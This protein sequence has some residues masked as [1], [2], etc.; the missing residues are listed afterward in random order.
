MT[1]RS[2]YIQVSTAV[3]KRA[4]AEKIARVMVEKKLAACVQIV[5]PIISIYRW[6]GRMERSKEW[7]LIIKTTKGH[8][9][10]VEKAIAGAH[11]YE[12]P[13]IIAVPIVAGSSLYLRWVRKQLR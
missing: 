9:A 1:D 2:R 13:E 5:G 11:P 10:R 3:S 12:L 6:K 7:L 4:H 8:Y